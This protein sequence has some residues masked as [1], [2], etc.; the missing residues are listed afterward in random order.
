MKSNSIII[1]SVRQLFYL[2]DINLLKFDQNSISIICFV[3]K[4]TIRINKQ[5]KKR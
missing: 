5:E 3:K 2:I 4:G 1:N